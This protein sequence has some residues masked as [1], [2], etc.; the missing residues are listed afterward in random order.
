MRSTSSFHACLVQKHRPSNLPSCKFGWCLG[1]TDSHQFFSNR[2]LHILLLR[3][4][5]KFSLASKH[6]PSSSSIF[7]FE[8]Q[9]KVWQNGISWKSVSG[10]STIVEIVGRNRWIIVLASEKSNEAAKIYSS[11]IRII[12]DLQKQLSKTSECLISPNLLTQY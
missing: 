6:I 1:C 7:G 12:L 4:A 2:F 9:C 8:R 10:V 3:L 11:V 5:F